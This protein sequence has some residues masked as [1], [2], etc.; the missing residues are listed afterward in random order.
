M[1]R[2]LLLSLVAVA[3]LCA[4]VMPGRNL[5]PFP[6]QL[7]AYLDL[8]DDQVASILRLN[9]SLNRFMA[10]K[11]TRNIQVQIEIAQEMRKE[12]L[13]P[14]ALGLRQV[15]LEAIRREIGAEQQKTAVEI[16]KVLTAAQ[17][18][19]LQALQEAMRLYNVGCDAIAINLMT[20]PAQNPFFGNVPGTP[21]P[22]PG[23]ATFL[24]G[25]VN[26]QPWCGTTAF[27]TGDFQFT[28]TPLP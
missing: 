24:L 8:K 11:N 12:T 27:R 25:A 2:V 5:V 3:P 28:P 16:Q 7:R 9:N 4:Q 14:M 18:M 21:A 13:D 19:K 23:F 6:P 26:T 17:K 15:E 1:L 22:E 20:Q 10:E